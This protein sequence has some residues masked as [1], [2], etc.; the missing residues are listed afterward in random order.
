M[1]KSV[2]TRDLKSLAVKSV[3]VR[4]RLPAPIKKRRPKPPL[5]YWYRHRTR[6]HFNATC[7]GHVAATSSKTGGYY[8]F[9]QSKNGSRVRLPAR[10]FSR[11]GKG[12]R[13][14]LPARPFSR[15]GKGSRVRLPALFLSLTFRKPPVYRI[16]PSFD[17]HCGNVG[18]S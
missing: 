13:V 6:T 10:P 12:N 9:L 8:T 16:L 14:R 3:P 1:V 17:L 2:D 7:R 11:S 4:V 5:F 18:L 15:S